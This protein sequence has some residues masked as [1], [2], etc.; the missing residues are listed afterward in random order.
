MYIRFLKISNLSAEGPRDSLKMMNNDV[1][2][3]NRMRDQLNV[4]SVVSSEKVNAR[5]TN[6]EKILSAATAKLL[7]KHRN[8]KR[9]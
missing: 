4:E 7:E 8:K 6:R 5:E 3:S 1:G 9:N 2:T